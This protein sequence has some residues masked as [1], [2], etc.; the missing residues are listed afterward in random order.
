MFEKFKRWVHS[1]YEKQINPNYQHPDPEGDKQ[2]GEQW[3][4]Y[5]QLIS[6][7]FSNS[8]DRRLQNINKHVGESNN[9]QQKPQPVITKK[10]EQKRTLKPQP[11]R[12]ISRERNFRNSQVG[13]TFR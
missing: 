11:V 7:Q 1:K 4:E 2:R 6:D 5:S 9:L 8:L 13:I 12:K 10:P 3:K